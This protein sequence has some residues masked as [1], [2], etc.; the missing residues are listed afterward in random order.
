MSTAKPANGSYFWI[1]AT[2]FGASIEPII[3]KMGYEAHCTPLQLLCL[4]SIVGAI[5]IWPLTRQTTWI[6]IEGLKKIAPVATL[7][8]CTST[9][10][11]CA[12]QFIQASMLITIATVTPAAVAL[13]NQ[14]LGR[15]VLGKKFWI[16]FCMCA[17]GLILTAGT[18]F[19]K[20]HFLG[21]ALALCAVG[22][23]TSYRV[24]LEKVTK[25]YKPALVSTYIFLINGICLLPVLPFIA[26][27]LPQNIVLSGLWLGIA[28]AVA[29][30]SFLYAISLLGSTRVSIITMLERPIIIVMAAIVLKEMLSPWQI[31][32]IIFVI[33]G[34]Q[35]AKLKHKA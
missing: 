16:G 34:V 28:A 32:G 20:I 4:K 11:L 2:L 31:A 6:G 23:S 1:T 14:A 19:G 18:D 8:L 3:A 12:L 21:I 29:N 17:C 24:L 10:S 7:L 35:L 15:D 30:V 26:K 5:V 33:V 13:V 25:E 27:S 9:L 22:T